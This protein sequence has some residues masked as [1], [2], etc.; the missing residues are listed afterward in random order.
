MSDPARLA[1]VTGGTKRVGAAI[2][3]QLAEAGYEVAVT[4][5]NAD[6]DSAH[7]CVES[8][9]DS[10]EAPLAILD[11]VQDRFGRLP[12]LIVNN[13][14]RFDHDDWRT[15]SLE[16]LEAHFRLNLHMPLLLA[17]ELARR[18]GDG[19]PGDPPCVIQIVD[20]RVRNPV[21]DQLS[22]TLSKQ[23][24]AESVRTM[25]LALAPR[26]RVNGVAPGLTLATG[27]YDARLIEAA[28]ASMPL[29]RLPV[30]TDIADAV[31][32]LARASSVTGQ[33]LFVDGGAA[34]RYFDRDFLFLDE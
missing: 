3:A 1:L 8:A 9:L 33:L 26:V 22:Y 7:Y 5:R 28:R 25:A 29:E 34:L 16:R 4:S 10:A 13:A 15:M 14:A 18:Q 23:A 27:E 12:D 20:Q 32:Y 2:G 6:G 21:P 30:P 17:T 24:L 11:A 19:R 31:L